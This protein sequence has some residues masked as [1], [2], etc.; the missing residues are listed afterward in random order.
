[1][2]VAIVTGH[3]FTASVLLTCTEHFIK[4]SIFIHLN[5]FQVFVEITLFRCRSK[6]YDDIYITFA[7]SS[8]C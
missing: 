5:P 2:S 3:I 1:M 8:V 6:F 7:V 4:T